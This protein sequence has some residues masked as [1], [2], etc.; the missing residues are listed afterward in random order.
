ME[1][2]AVP[3]KKNVEDG[4]QMTQ[5]ANAII[6]NNLYLIVKLPVISN[7]FPSLTVRLA[8]GLIT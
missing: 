8:P 2:A 7:C 3:D 5:P 4:W 1:F 6:S